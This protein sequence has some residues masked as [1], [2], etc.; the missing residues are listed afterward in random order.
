MKATLLFV[1]L[2]CS[3][4]A[5]AKDRPPHQTGRLISM[6]AVP[7]G[8]TAN[9]SK[10]AASSSAETGSLTTNAQEPP[11]QEYV[12][13]SEHVTYHIRPR[14]VK[15]TAILPLG[16]EADFRFH[17]D[18]MI[19][20]VPEGDNKERQYFVISMTLRPESD[21]VASSGLPAKGQR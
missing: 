20:R 3:G 10:N 6:D 18:K 7:C 12:L 17:G 9:T 1:I 8:F 14:D 4:L 16:E 2:I 21:E 13:E 19:L 15:H 11:C 5:L